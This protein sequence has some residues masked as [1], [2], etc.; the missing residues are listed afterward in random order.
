[1]ITRSKR[2]LEI[3]APESVHV[4]QLYERLVDVARQR[5]RSGELTE[6]G[7][8]RLCGVSQPHIH[9]VLK[10]IR[11]LSPASADRLMQALGVSLP[12]LM[13]RS[14]EDGSSV[15]VVPMVRH[16]IGPGMDSTLTVFRGFMPFSARAVEGL[17]NPLAA[18]L[19]PDLVLP[20]A[21][22]ANDLILL[23][24][25]PQVR[26]EPG[27]DSY[28]V[29]SELGGLRVRYVKRG[30]RRIYLANDATARDPKLW[31]AVPLHEREVTDIVLARIVWIGR[32]LVN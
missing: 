9:N 17:V 28:W 2:T 16:K 31:D 4:E 10:Q 25:N 21:L 15:R 18:Q 13:W 24:Q 29:V 26:A 8:S 11:A 23:D 22:S 20:A 32:D 5:I 27:G 14:T 3:A 7:L 30:A 6:R 1:L 19:G 12:E